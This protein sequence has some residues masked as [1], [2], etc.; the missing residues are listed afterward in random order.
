MPARCP[1]AGNRL[2]PPS[3]ALRRGDWM[4]PA[5]T[6]REE[7][8]EVPPTPIW[9]PDA[10]QCSLCGG[11]RREYLFVVEQSRMTRCHECGL[12]S[13]TDGESQ[14]ADG[15]ARSYLLDP[16]AEGAVRAGLHG[17]VLQVVLGGGG[18]LAVDGTPGGRT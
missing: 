10:I 2:L 11:R 8:D 14:G 9:Q 17:R 13:K 5:V 1:S 16:V 3:D 6:L 15:D 12:I 7:L 4:K 18:R